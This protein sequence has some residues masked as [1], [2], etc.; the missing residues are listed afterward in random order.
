MS[1]T[2]TIATKPP[3]KSPSE[4]LRCSL[5]GGHE[6]MGVILKVHQ[7]GAPTQKGTSTESIRDHP[8]IMASRTDVLRV[9]RSARDKERYGPRSQRH[10]P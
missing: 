5:Q 2:K 1:K 10:S 6:G 4:M 9:A 8:Q 3:P 7:F